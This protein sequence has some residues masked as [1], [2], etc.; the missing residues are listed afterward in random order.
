MGIWGLPVQSRGWQTWEA[1]LWL[2]LEG[3]FLTGI[4]ARA[5]GWKTPALYG[6]LLRWG[7]WG[8]GWKQICRKNLS[9]TIGFAALI[10]VIS[11]LTEG[12]APPARYGRSFLLFSLGN[13]VQALLLSLLEIGGFWKYSLPCCMESL[14][15]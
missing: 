12:P 1:F 11:L 9:Y 15:S 13:Y 7:D 3:L 2:L 14:F 6:A 4:S 8:K 5:E 10:S